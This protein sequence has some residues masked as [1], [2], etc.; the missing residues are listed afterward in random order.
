MLTIRRYN[1]RDRHSYHASNSHTQLFVVLNDSSEYYLRYFKV[2]YLG[3][4]VS[5]RRI[6]KNSNS[7]LYTANFFF[8]AFIYGIIYGIV[9]MLWVN[10]IG[11]DR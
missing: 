6:R 10:P 5:T 11:D 4:G 7:S 3:R 2:P 9:L 8:I 1:I